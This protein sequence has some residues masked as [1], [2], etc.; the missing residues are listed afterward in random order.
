MTTCAAAFFIVV[1][2]AFGAIIGSFLNVRIYRPPI[3]KSIVAGLGVRRAGVSC[4]GSRTPGVASM[5]GRC[6]TCG[7]PLSAVS[8]VEALSA[9]M[10]RARGAL[11]PTAAAGRAARLGCAPIVLFVIDLEHHLLPNVTLPGIVVGFLSVSSPSRWASS[12]IGILVGGG[13][14][15]GVAEVH[16]VHEEGPAWATGR[17]WR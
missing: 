12:L 6:R 5:R 15:Y 17:C 16:R 9:A 4:R 8:A 3:E 14:P 7:A 11:R 10:L 1:A 13:V 2:A